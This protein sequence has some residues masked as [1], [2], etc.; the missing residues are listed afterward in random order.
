MT[1]MP[2]PNFDLANVRRYES[3]CRA[4]REVIIDLS[5][6]EWVNTEAV[7]FMLRLHRDGVAVRIVHPPALFLKTLN[8]LQ[9]NAAFSQLIAPA[10][11]LTPEPN[12]D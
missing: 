11:R 1:V 2:H 3:R 7:A 10:E 5:A 6:C 9:L 12:H 8:D 4:A